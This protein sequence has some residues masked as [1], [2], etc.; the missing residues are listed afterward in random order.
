MPCNGPESAASRIIAFTSSTLVSRAAIKDRS[1]IDTLSVG[2]RIAKPSSL[3]FNSGNTR[4]TA[5]AAPV[6]VGI[7]L[8]VALRARQVRV[9]DIAQHLVVGIGVHRGHQAIDHADF[10]MQGLNQRRKA[11]R[12]A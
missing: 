11:V 8:W 2:T 1:T 10:L 9:V 12:R 3:P 5:A 7:M 4:P 6:F